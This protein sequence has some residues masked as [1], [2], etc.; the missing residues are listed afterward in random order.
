MKLVNGMKTQYSLLLCASVTVLGGLQFVHGSET[1]ADISSSAMQDGLKVPWGKVTEYGLFNSLDKGR[2]VADVQS[3]TGKMIRGVKVEFAKPATHIPLRKGT[4]FGYRYWLKLPPDQ[5]RPK[6]TRRLIH[7]DMHLPDGTQ[8][9][10]S[11]RVITRKA[12]HGIV[13][14]LDIYALSEAYE[15]VE[16]EWVFQIWFD[17]KMLVSQGFTTYWPET[18]EKEVSE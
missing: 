18:E 7:P 13:T 17:G 8:V 9:N 16:G 5:Y 1:S 14:S 11:E 15:L 10:W 6:L 3:N 2:V 4:Y 12:T